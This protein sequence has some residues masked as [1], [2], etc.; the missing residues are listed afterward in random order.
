MKIPK[1]IKLDI[2]AL[3]E[4]TREKIITSIIPTYAI[5]PQS[6]LACTFKNNPYT[7]L[8]KFPSLNVFDDGPWYLD[9][10]THVIYSGYD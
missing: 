7:L 1:I 4:I 5:Y 10:S 8:T 3:A 9:I 6:H 2:K